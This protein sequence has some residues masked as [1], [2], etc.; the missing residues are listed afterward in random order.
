[1]AATDKLARF[2]P[3]A[4]ELAD[5]EYVRA[6]LR[7]GV[8]NLRA[9]YER[10]QKRPV[11]AARDEKLRR[12][13]QSAAS[14]LTEAGRALVSGRRKPQ[15]RRGRRVALL[16]AISAGAA[17]ALASSDGLRS[18]LFGDSGEGSTS[19]PAPAPPAEA[20]AT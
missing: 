1:M 15:R 7:S 5:N 19:T 11:K 3:Y 6:N 9:A 8:E 18:S 13:V 20:V 4:S 12:Q 14:S 16:L 2:G 17:V 10:S